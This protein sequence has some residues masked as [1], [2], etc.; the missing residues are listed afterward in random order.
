[1]PR[2]R[3]HLRRNRSGKGT[4]WVILDGPSEHSTGCGGDDLGGAEKALQRHIAA[5]YTPPRTSRPEA[6]LISEVML[7]YL[8]E[9]APTRI[10][11][12]WIAAM[13]TP[14]IKWWGHRP[15]SEIRGASC[16]EYV[17]WRTAQRVTE[18]TAGHE[19]TVLRAALHYYHRKY[20]PLQSVPSITLPAKK[21]QKRDYFWT[22]DEAA[23]R[24]RAAR[25]RPETRHLVRLILIGLYSGT[26][27]NAMLRLRWLPSSVRGWID[28]EAGLLHRQGAA[29]ARTA[30]RQPTCRIHARLVRHLYAWKREDERHGISHVIHYAARP[31]R[32][33]INTAWETIR[34]EAGATKRDTA[35]ILRHTAI[36]WLLQS[37]VDP[38][39]VSGYVGASLK[40]IESTYLHHHP[41][42]QQAASQAI[43]KKSRE[44]R[45]NKMA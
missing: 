19:L 43:P 3:L 24:I 15:V 29:A 35:H 27:L 42:F 23:R 28:L 8:R 38:V 12:K 9:R 22:R 25:R 1:M 45:R 32:R 30:K 26:R 4:T 14:I 6:L 36:T 40:V 44:P 21:P 39:Q 37:G 7:A 31:I 5:N 2:K 41:S 33:R 13:A 34:R 11:A 20:G 10:S 18:V 17:A 16:R